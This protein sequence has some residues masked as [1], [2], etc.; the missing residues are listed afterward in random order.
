[1]I[2]QTSTLASQPVIFQI[3]NPAVIATIIGGIMAIP[4]FILNYQNAKIQRQKSERDEIYKKLNSFYGPIRL[5]LK[6]SRN[7]Y[8]I[9]SN[10]IKQRLQIR[11]FK[12][13]PYILDGEDFTKTESKLLDQ[14]IEIGKNIENIIDKNA[15]LIDS[16]GVNEEMIKLGIHIRIIREARNGGYDIGVNKLIPLQEH[17]FPDIEVKIDRIFKKFKVRL[18][19][20]NNIKTNN[21]D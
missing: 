5:Q 10:S 3:L 18:N 11:E 4:G 14:I 21:K 19:T 16:D 15:G 20:L 17:T 9:F 7:L 2:L 6:M 8:L 12:T 1:M 13:L